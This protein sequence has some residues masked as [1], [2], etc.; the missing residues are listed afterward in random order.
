MSAAG[1]EPPGLSARK[2][3]RSPVNQAA[4]NCHP[5]GAAGRTCNQTTGQCTCKDGVTGQSCNRCAAGYIQS[6]SSIAPCIKMPDAS[7]PAQPPSSA[8]TGSQH[9]P[10]YG[11]QRSPSPH[12]DSATNHYSSNDVNARHA[13]NY[14]GDQAGCGKCKVGRR[15]ITVQKYCRRDY[16]VLG[17]V[18]N[19][20][21][22]PE[23][24]R[25]D[26]Q[27]RNV[28]KRNRSVR[29]RRGVEQ[30]WVKNADLACKCPK[31][32]IGSEYL[33]LGK[34]NGRAPKPGLLV[35]QRSI[36]LEWRNSWTLR[37]RRLD[38][39]ASQAKC[40]ARY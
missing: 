12:S 33:I 24:T 25:F 22:G 5:V 37:M 23:Y 3:I 7:A 15:R 35:N 1:F 28:F 30:L 39:K 27:I 31:L 6:R 40:R 14:A 17:F 32:K 8:N 36:V 13:Y 26:L 38:K 29:V 2:Q 10:P 16:A 20:E 34:Q 18:T 9:T 11:V 21:V 19:S 4:C